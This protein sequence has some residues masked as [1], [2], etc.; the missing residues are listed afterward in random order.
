VKKK[1]KLTSFIVA[2]M[3][4]LSIHKMSDTCT[5]SQSLDG[6]KCDMPMSGEKKGLSNEINV[7]MFEGHLRKGLCGFLCNYIYPQVA[8]A[9][10]AGNSVVGLDH[11]RVSQ[12]VTVLHYRVDSWQG[13]QVFSLHHHVQN[14]SRLYL[15]S[16]TE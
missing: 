5:A 10:L 9:L 1:Y 8:L 15:A 13:C 3:C 4:E 16:H 2:K 11:Q 14:K 6:I 12:S 7:F